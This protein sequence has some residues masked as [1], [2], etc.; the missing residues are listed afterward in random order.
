[1]NWRKHSLILAG[2]LLILSAC[3]ENPPA[4]D[5]LFSE[6]PASYTGIDFENK[7]EFRQDFNIYTYRNFYNGGGVAIGDVNK[8]GLPDIYFTGNMLPN[9]LYL[10]RGNWKFEDVTEAAGV[11]GQHSWSTGV[12]MADVNGDGWLD[13]YVCNSGDVEGDGRQNELFI[14]KGVAEGDE[15]GIPVYEEKAAEY[16]LA[17]HGL[18]THAAF[19]DYDKDGDLDMYLLNNS[20]RAIGSFDFEVNE[21]LERDSVGGDKLFRNDGNKF[22]DVS[23]AAGIYGS[24]VG[25]GLGVTIG[26]VDLDGWQD[27]YVSNDFFERDYLYINNHDGT[28]REELPQQMASISA[29]SMGADCADVNGDGWPEIFV[30]EM[31]PQD[32]DRIKTKTTF[33]NWNRLQLSIKSDYYR[34]FTRNMLQ[35]NNGDGTFSEIG[36]LAGVE[37]TDWSWGALIQD[38]NNDGHKDIFVANGIYQDLTDQD[39][40]QF[41]AADETKKAVISREGVD[42]RKLVEFIPSEPVPNYIFENT[43]NWDPSDTSLQRPFVN[44]AEEWG[45]A[46]PG[47]SNGSAYADLDNDGDL[48]LVVNNLNMPPFLYR[49]NTETFHPERNWLE[50]TLT[51]EAPNNYAVGA[52]I[53]AWAGGNCHYLEHNPIR[54]FESSMDYR[55]HLGLGDATVIDSLAVIWYSGKMSRL[56]AVPVNQQ[57]SLKEQD[58][59]AGGEAYLAMCKQ[60]HSTGNPL[61]Q[62]FS[63]SLAQWR[64]KE[65]LFVDFDRDRLIY[66]M[67][68]TEGPK[69]ATGDVNG[70]GLTDVFFGNAKDSP[71]ALFV[72]LPGGSFR[73]TNQ[74]LWDESAGAEDLGASFFDADGDGD[75]DLYVAS[76]GNEFSAGNFALKDR[77]YLNDGR[78]NFTDTKTVQPAGRLESSSCVKAADFDGDGDLDLFVGVRVLP[79]Y[80]GVPP[81]SY[82]LQNDGNGNFTDVTDQ[83]APSLRKVGMVTDAVWLDADGDGDQDLALTGEWMPVKL[84]L[85]EGGKLNEHPYPALQQTS[86]WWNCL[87]AADV[88]NDGDMDLIAGGHGLNS[89]FRASEEKPIS[90]YINDFDQNGSVEQIICQYN[91]DKSYPLVLRHDLISQM[92][93]MKKKYLKYESYKGQTIED[94]FTPEQLKNSIVHEV[95]RLQSSLLINDGKGNFKVQNLPMEAQLSP[96]YAIL[97]NDFDGDGNIDLLLGGNLLNVKPEMGQYD[98]SFGCYLKGNGNGTFTWLPPAQSGIKIKGEIRDFALLE[99]GNAPLLI[100]ARN[101]D[102][103]VVLVGR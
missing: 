16:G 78:G 45:I 53:Y 51:G 3:T 50:L 87:E 76:G 101:N 73:P 100:V 41:I 98:A 24:I 63:S 97:P 70:D 74:K 13:I 40:L 75:L 95:V 34:Q 46:K 66:H 11:A 12:A 65:N 57:L 89:R 68:S 64:H 15:K 5:K 35:R 55:A 91:G 4:P 60:Q 88:D 38:F 96:V 80:Y 26:D 6:M 18:S 2:G 39:F 23:E 93:E 27:I 20:F 72:Q 44:R 47:F 9:R 69:I 102:T 30:T 90:C 71:A 54:G 82:L 92:R 83:L 8:D 33:D 67:I 77:L 17:D 58:A 56:T 14:S 7:L 28:F 85:N 103:P 48:D 42:F 25:F 59:V 29:A 94:L 61:F 43:G 62:P 10:N 52:K 22:T 86:G 19:F 32:E 49:N 21:R 84:F 37:A 36:R 79:F 99:N 1:M 81:N 31:L